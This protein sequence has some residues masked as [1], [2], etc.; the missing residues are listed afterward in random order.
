MFPTR[1]VTYGAVVYCPKRFA[2]LSRACVYPPLQGL[3]ELPRMQDYERWAVFTI[4]TGLGNARFSTRPSKI[5]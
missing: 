4:G 3:S 2:A 5:E 1:L